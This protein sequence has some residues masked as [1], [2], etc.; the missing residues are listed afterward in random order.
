MAHR[1]L[2]RSARLW[3][4]GL[5]LG[6]AAILGMLGSV[7]G[8]AGSDKNPAKKEA[9][10]KKKAPT[11]DLV[12]PAA[13]TKVD[14]L[15]LSKIIDQEIQKR[16]DEENIKPSPRSDDAEFVRRVYL[17]LTGVVPTPDKVK[18]FLQ[19]K[20]P[21]KRRKL[22]DELLS[23]ARFGTSLAETWANLMIPRESNNRLLQSTPLQTWL[24]E[25]F[26]ANKPLNEV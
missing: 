14:A 11:A 20:D 1:M 15:A 17:D 13:G 10:G 22:I 24:T 12:V 8:Q 9:K 21:E 16:L 6:L 3:T 7:Q 19:S 5:F 25:K 26:N 23:E 18:E 4:T 2:P